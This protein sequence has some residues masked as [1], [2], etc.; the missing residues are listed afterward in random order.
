MNF[1]FAC[2]PLGDRGL[3]IKLTRDDA[4]DDLSTSGLIADQIRAS[5]VKGVTDI[6]PAFN[7]LAVHYDPTQW[8]SS[9]LESPYEEIVRFLNHKLTGI[10]FVLEPTDRKV[11]CIPVC[12]DEKVGL[13]L[14]ELS[15]YLNTSTSDLINLHQSNIYTVGA[16]GFAPGFAYLEGLDASLVVPRRSEPRTR[17]PA[18]SVAIAGGYTGIYPSVLPGGWYILGRTYA[19]L[20]RTEESFGALLRVGDHVRFEPISIE[21]LDAQRGLENKK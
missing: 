21:E 5:N 3:I 11:M 18:G 9:S 17:V 1:R 6:V 13:D 16:I 12:Y 4:G 10:E 2:A 7:Q 15:S 20:F 19:S 8:T 14:L